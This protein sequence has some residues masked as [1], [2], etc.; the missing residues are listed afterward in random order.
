MGAKKKDDCSFGEWK[1]VADWAK[2]V[3]LSGLLFY[4]MEW[5]MIAQLICYIYVSSNYSNT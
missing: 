3:F 4:P 1:L 5:T 2:F